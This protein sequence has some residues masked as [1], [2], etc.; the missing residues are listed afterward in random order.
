MRLLRNLLL[1]GALI[2]ASGTTA[3]AEPG[4]Y[5]AIVADE[6]RLPAHRELDS[7]RHPAIVLD[8]ASVKKGDVV[9]DFLAGTGYFTE[10]VA[11][12][13]GRDGR[14]YAMNPP[15]F[16]DEKSWSVL[17]RQHPNA[18]ALLA[19]MKFQQLAPGS[20]DM[21]LSHL[22]FHDLYWESEQ[23]DYPRLDVPGILRNWHAALRKGGTVVIVDHYGPEGDT[24]A[25]VEATHRI[26]AA[27]VISEMEQAGFKLV[28]R[29]EA[30]ANTTDD[31]GVSV[32]DKSV[33]GKT[34]RFMLKFA[35]D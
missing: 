20:V 3:V 21:I 19:P 14:A 17:V 25:I 22:T 31:P 4:D 9:A 23:Y 35:R 2:L 11:A 1:P 7:M 10:M 26:D 15:N 12:I 13:V 24:R 27:R 8:F 29:S 16:H 18:S 30:L 33:R 32:F 5:A 28:G 34:S 6:A